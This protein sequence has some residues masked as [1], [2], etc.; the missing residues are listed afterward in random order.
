M[1]S[2]IPTT[3]HNM[4]KCEYKLIMKLSNVKRKIFQY[5]VN[6]RSYSA[7]SLFLTKYCLRLLNSKTRSSE[8][9]TNKIDNFEKL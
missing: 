7:Y 9:N 4:K 5:V 6:A 2:P 1:T 8:R 3:Y